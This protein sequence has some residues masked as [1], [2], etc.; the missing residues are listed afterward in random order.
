SDHSQHCRTGR[1][2]R[3]CSQAGGR[4]NQG[5][6]RNS[7]STLPANLR[8]QLETAV[9]QARKIAEGGAR[10]A[11]EALAVHEPDPYRHM[12]EDQQDLRLKLRAQAEQLGDDES[13]DRRGSYEIKHLVDKLAYDQ[14]HR[15]L[16]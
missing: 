3:R 15:L 5:R 8:R 7:M 9:K 1:V 12:D 16:F 11:L 13:P 10:K 4:K 14:W 6:P 2:A